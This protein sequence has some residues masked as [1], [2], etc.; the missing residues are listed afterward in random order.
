MRY[1]RENNFKHLK[2]SLET[3]QLII[4]KQMRHNQRN[5]FNFGFL[6]KTNKM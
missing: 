4:I 3:L 6:F 5:E 1:L 2:I